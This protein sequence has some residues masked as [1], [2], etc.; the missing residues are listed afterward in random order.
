MTDDWLKD[1]GPIT[2]IGISPDRRQL[3]VERMQSVVAL[4]EGW[5]YI[6]IETIELLCAGELVRKPSKRKRTS[7]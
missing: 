1:G 4:H 2:Q 5:T 6:P 7:P 3:V